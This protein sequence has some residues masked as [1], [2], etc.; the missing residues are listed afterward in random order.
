MAEIL[1][2]LIMSE[3]NGGKSCRVKKHS[4]WQCDG[5]PNRPKKGEPGYHWQAEM[6]WLRHLKYRRDNLAT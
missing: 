1:E 5:C 4:I 3:C 2:P 6:T